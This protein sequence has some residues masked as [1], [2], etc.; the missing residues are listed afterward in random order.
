MENEEFEKVSADY[1]NGFNEGYTLAEHMPDV[2]EKVSKALG[3]GDRAK[4]FQDGRGQLL[5]EKTQEKLAQKTAVKDS[6][7]HRSPSKDLE[8]ER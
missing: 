2:A 5:L 6:P 7:E 3:D 1:L 8:P 4:G